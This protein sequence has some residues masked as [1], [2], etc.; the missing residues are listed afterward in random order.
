LDS[1]V[2]SKIIKEYGTP[3]FIYN[4]EKIKEQYF[5]LKNALPNH[6]KIYYS[7]KANPTLGICQIIHTLTPNIEV[8]SLGEIYCAL[9]AGFRDTNILYSGPGKRL[10]EIKVALKQKIKIN[11]ESYQEVLVIEK[12]CRILSINATL[13]LRINPGKK[14]LMNSI[15]MTGISS[16]FGV[17]DS[18]LDDIIEYINNSQYMNLV[19][20]S[21]YYGSQILNE[22]LI[23]ANCEEI[24]NIAVNACKKYGLQLQEIDFGGGF[25]VNYFHEK[26]LNIS[27][28]CNK[29]NG[30]FIKY[31][32]TLNNVHLAFESGRFLLADS[33]C[34]LT[35]VLYKKVSKG[36]NY[37]ICDGGLNHILGSSFYNRE[38]RENFPIEVFNKTGSR[39]DYYITG[40]LCTPKDIFGKKVN[41]VDTEVND[42]IIVNKV[43]AYGYT[44]SPSRFISH[45]A[46]AE[47]I[48]IYN[49]PYLLRKREAYSDLFQNQLILR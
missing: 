48:I 40:P 9:K 25:G 43:G 31:K 26:D 21:V 16:Q 29:L 45:L 38:V 36:K 22:E 35:K 47:V 41:I 3:V 44:F 5:K 37:L 14:H 30:L 27:E 20:I 33:G 34:Y 46:P 12:L 10:Q 39:K 1:K 15:I 18:E 11:V 19:G 32:N 42:Y 8:S 13:F 28:L 17:E 6:S 2:I 23:I 49:K 4:Y 24:I 7:M